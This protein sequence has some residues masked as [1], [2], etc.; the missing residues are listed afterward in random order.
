MYEYGLFSTTLLWI[1]QIEQIRRG[2]SIASI[3]WLVVTYVKSYKITLSLFS[4]VQVKRHWSFSW[5]TN[6]SLE[7]HWGSF[8]NLKACGQTFDLSAQLLPLGFIAIIALHVSLLAQAAIHYLL[9]QR[10]CCI[11]EL[12]LFTFLALQICHLELSGK[13]TTKFQICNQY[14]VFCLKVLIT[15]KRFICKLTFL[16]MN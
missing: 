6:L 8:T 14:E 12:L 2:S 5:A 7:H 16:L 4:F 1:S 13:A 9:G 11:K 3:F 10:N 15:P